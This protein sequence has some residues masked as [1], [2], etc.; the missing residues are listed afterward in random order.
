MTSTFTNTAKKIVSLLEKYPADKVK[1]YASFKFSQIERFCNIGSIPIP[2]KILE[3]QA[4]EQKKQQKLIK[5]DVQKLKRM[6]FAD[7]NAAPNY[8]KELF[9]ADIL[10]QQYKSLKNIADNKWADHY[11]VDKKLLEPKGNP[12]YYARLMRDVNRGGQERESIFDA[13]R[14]IITGKY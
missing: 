13:F 3:E 6:I 7:E 4:L 12:N 8:K 5:I 11:K 10:N 9:D 14:T 1:H 2:K